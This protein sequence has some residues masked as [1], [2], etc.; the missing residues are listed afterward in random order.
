M[1]TITKQSN[2]PTYITKDDSTICELMHPQQQDNSNQS[3]AQAS[4][5]VNKETQLHYH[6]I[7]EELYYIQ[8]GTGLMT[9]NHEQFTVEAGDTI[10]IHPE[11]HHK[12]KNTGNCKLVF[13]CC[14]SPAYNHDDT[15]LLTDYNEA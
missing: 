6:R 4:V 14:C 15:Y 9:I 2:L 11:Q 5:A 3:L 8:Q 13:L 12:I 1:P 7:S 10:C